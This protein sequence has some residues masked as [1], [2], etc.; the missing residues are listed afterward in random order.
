MDFKKHALKDAIGQKKNLLWPLEKNL[1]F[2]K[3]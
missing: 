3:L 2:K 1:Y